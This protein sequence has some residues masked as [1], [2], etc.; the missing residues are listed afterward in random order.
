MDCSQ[1]GSSVHGIFF[2]GKNTGAGCHFPFQG[3]LP[4]QGSNPHLPHCRQF[5]TSWA[6]ELLQN[7][8][9][10]LRNDEDRKSV[11]LVSSCFS[12]PQHYSYSI[13]QIPLCLKPFLQPQLTANLGK[14]K[15]QH[16]VHLPLHDT[17]LCCWENFTL[18]YI[19]NP[20]WWGSWLDWKCSCSC[21]QSAQPTNR[22]QVTL[23]GSTTYHHQFHGEHWT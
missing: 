2:P 21:N 12:L 11:E 9:S 22:A 18:K 3:I 6:T 17:L 20:E 7:P 5:F 1:P 4:T 19:V 14:Q 8:E 16:S 13:L 23:T 10:A 15:P